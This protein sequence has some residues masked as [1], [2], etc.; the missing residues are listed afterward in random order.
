MSIAWLHVLNEHPSNLKKYESVFT[1]NSF[2]FLGRLKL[3]VWHFL[4]LL[5]SWTQKSSADSRVTECSNVD[6]IIVSH[7]L[8]AGQ[9][10]EAEDFYFGRIADELSK[11]GLKTLVILRNHTNWPARAL[12][13]RWAT[14][15]S[16]RR[17]LPNLLGFGEE[18]SMRWRLLR[19]S[20][21]LKEL[22]RR[23]SPGLQR[24]VLERAAMKALASDSVATLRFYQQIKSIVKKHGARTI[25]VTYEGH[26]W[27]RLAFSAARSVLPDIRCIGYQH[28]ILFP[29]Q[30]AINRQLALQFNP[31]VILTAGE[32]TR[33][34]LQEASELQ[35]VRIVSVGTHRQEEPAMTISHKVQQGL[36]PTCLVIPDGTLDE[37]LTILGVVL[38]AAALAPEIRFIVRMHPV[39]PFSAVAQVDQRLQ[40]MPR[41][42]V[43]STQSLVADFDEC[44]W[45]IYRG[46]GAAI[47]AVVAGLRP[48]YLSN[49]DE[50]NIDPINSLQVWRTRICTP[51]ELICGI[52]ADLKSDVSALEEEMIVAREFCRKYFMP[53][54]VDRFCG[55]ISGQAPI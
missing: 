36:P 34:A 22:A 6:V 46:S 55:E 12:E 3:L 13:S 43:E 48:F 7:I 32:V 51:A 50:L 38:E 11:R 47:R 49:P 8:N 2:D 18:L 35:A 40:R 53:V 23:A 42:M 19:E 9:A 4:Q 41:N 45:A 17:I 26:G 54:D 37:C 24:R 16:P 25:A 52:S 31:D 30:H 10:G 1:R 39:M 14:E 29:R 44:R 27:E 5:N 21:Q 33:E 28:A 15:C 20:K